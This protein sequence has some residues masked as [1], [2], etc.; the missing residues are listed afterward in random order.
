M[1]VKNCGVIEAD[2][3]DD[4]IEKLKKVVAEIE[5]HGPDSEDIEDNVKTCFRHIA[6]DKKIWTDELHLSGEDFDA[7]VEKYAKEADD[8]IKADN[9]DQAKIC[10]RWEKEAEEGLEELDDDDGDD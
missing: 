2:N 6:V 3:L 5:H 9:K 10:K 7:M 4:A 1:K 8:F